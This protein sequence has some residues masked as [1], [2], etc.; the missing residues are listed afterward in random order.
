MSTPTRLTP[1]QKDVLLR[2]AQGDLTPKIADDLGISVSTVRSYL[3]ELRDLMYATN[4]AHAC[5]LAAKQGLLYF[6]EQGNLCVH[7]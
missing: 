1:R 3:R 6:D 4:T 2:Y 5:L 7:A